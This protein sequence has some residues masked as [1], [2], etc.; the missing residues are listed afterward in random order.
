MMPPPPTAAS[1][2]AERQAVMDRLQQYQALQS[3]AQRPRF[4]QPLQTQQQPE[5][6]SQTQPV[7]QSPFQVQ[8]APE[9]AASQGAMTVVSSQAPTEVGT[10]LVQVPETTQQQQPLDELSAETQAAAAVV[11][12]GAASE[13]A[14]PY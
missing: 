4:A 12:T 10:Q 9:P 3:E 7:S 6:L 2:A 5:Q 1:I 13:R 8:Q 11:S 14:R